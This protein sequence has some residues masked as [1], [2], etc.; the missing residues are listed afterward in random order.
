MRDSFQVFDEF[1]FLF[2][3]RFVVG[4][5]QGIGLCVASASMLLWLFTKGR[6]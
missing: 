6:P 1:A 4:G 5:A 2:M 3:T